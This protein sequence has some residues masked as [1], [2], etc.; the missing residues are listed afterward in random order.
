MSVGTTL[1]PVGAYEL[2]CL[3]SGFC[4]G[5]R[6][7][8]RT[9]IALPLRVHAL[10][11]V[12]LRIH[13]LHLACLSLCFA[14]VQLCTPV[15]QL[16][17]LG[18]VSVSCS[19]YQMFPAPRGESVAMTHRPH[20][21]RLRVPTGNYPPQGR[22]SPGALACF[23]PAVSCEASLSS[24]AHTL[25]VPESLATLRRFKLITIPS[26]ALLLYVLLSCSR[27]IQL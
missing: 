7:S 22:D 4:K 12:A 26:P 14:K 10:P 25:C 1:M 6:R 19:S 13:R 21:S 24:F 15:P 20:I 9:D 5:R 17:G 11:S 18:R 2:S 27:A 16:D 8:C 3:V 23:S